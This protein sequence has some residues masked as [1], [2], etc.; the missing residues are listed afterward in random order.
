MTYH[1][2]QIVPL[3]YPDRAFTDELLTPAPWMIFRVPS[4]GEVTFRAW[5][6]DSHPGQVSEIWWPVQRDWIKGRDGRKV[7]KV[8]AAIPGYVFVKLLFEPVMHVLFERLGPKCLGVVMRGDR[9]LTFG[10][11][12]LLEMQDFGDRA[13]EA[14]NEAARTEAERYPPKVGSKGRVLAGP[15]KGLELV[16]MEV[17]PA[18]V[19][20]SLGNGLP[21]R[22]DRASVRGA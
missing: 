12:T 16:V 11:D 18:H 22:A 13:Q 8:R 6:S 21:I 1:I 14:V 2:G 19:I 9:Y 17:H 15:L 3:D 10:E 5:L 7:P 4:G 20:L